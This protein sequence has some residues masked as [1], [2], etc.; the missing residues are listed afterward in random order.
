MDEQNF[1]DEPSDGESK[2]LGWFAMA[3]LW[4]GIGIALHIILGRA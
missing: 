1:F 4:A 2:W 3:L